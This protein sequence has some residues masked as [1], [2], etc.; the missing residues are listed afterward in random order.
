MDN[1]VRAEWRKA[2]GNTILVGCTIWLYPVLGLG[3]VV[4]FAFLLIAD[5]NFAELYEENVPSWTEYALFGWNAVFEELGILR[6]PLLGFIAYVFANEY[7]LKTWKSVLPGN[8][9]VQVLGAKFIA[10]A[11]FVV[12]AL[13]IMSLVTTIGMGILN[14]IKGLPYPPALT[15]GNVGE[16]LV[17]FL[18]LG[19]LSFVSMIMLAG[20]AAFLAVITRSVAFSVAGT[21]IASLLETVAIRIPVGLLVNEF[22]F[23]NVIYLYL[24]LPTYNISN[25]RSFIDTGEPYE[26]ILMSDGPEFPLWLSVA[27]LAGWTVFFTV[28]SMRIFSKQDF[29]E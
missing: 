26:Y 2:T 29:G 22:D 28:S 14:L 23:E 6:L 4:L 5:P 25:I 10:V 17:E 21:L 19:L 7:Q 11:L 12:L 1:L 24:V 9:R 16:F 8:R 20:L 27:I 15:P 3:L 13:S 18:L